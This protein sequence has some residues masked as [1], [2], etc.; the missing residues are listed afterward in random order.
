VVP[1]EESVNRIEQALASSHH[2]HYE[3]H[4]IPAATHLL[5]LTSPEPVGMSME[6]MHT[7]FH[8]VRIGPGVRELMA[9]WA[10]GC[11]SV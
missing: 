11:F 2:S 1:R 6:T 5:Y 3:L 9:D 4:V 7:H 8:N 10:L